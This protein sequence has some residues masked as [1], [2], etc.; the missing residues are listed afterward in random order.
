[1]TFKATTKMALIYDSNKNF[2]GRRR[3][4]EQ[5][6]NRDSFVY[7]NGF[8]ESVYF[9]IHRKGYTIAVEEE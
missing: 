7:I 4:Y 9:L 2:I 6:D 3:I 5:K 1:M 8:I